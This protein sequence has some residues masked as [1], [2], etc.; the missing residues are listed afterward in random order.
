MSSLN[1]QVNKYISDR[2]TNALIYILSKAPILEFFFHEDLVSEYVAKEGISMALHSLSYGFALTKKIMYV[3]ILA[4]IIPEELQCHV[5]VFFSIIGSLLSPII[6]F[7]MTEYEMIMLMRA[8]STRYVR[9]QLRTFIIKDVA[10]MGI[11]L[12]LLHESFLIE[13]FYLLLYLSIHLIIEGFRI[14]LIER[15]GFEFLKPWINTVILGSAA[16]IAVAMYFLGLTIRKQAL[17]FCVLPLLVCGCLCWYYLWKYPNYRRMHSYN[18]TID[19]INGGARNLQETS[20]PKISE[21]ERGS[22]EKGFYYINKIFLQRYRSD[23]IGTI[24]ISPIIA[25]V[26]GTAFVIVPFFLPELKMNIMHTIFDKL[27]LLFYLMYCAAQSYQRYIRLNFME[28]DR[29]MIS[30]SFYRTK[31][32]ISLNLR[33][34]LRNV[35]LMGAPT[36]FIISVALLAGFAIHGN[37]EFT[38][39]MLTVAALLPLILHVFFAIYTVAMYYL[40]QP[41]SF[42]GTSASKV[43]NAIN[44]ILY[45]VVYFIFMTDELTFSPLVL[46]IIT[47]ILAVISAVLFVLVIKLAPSNFRVRG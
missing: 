15:N 47:A 9:H 33:L 43:Y 13:L 25:L 46:M 16:A 42:D 32:A 36:A 17:L 28:L 40:L 37:G 7:S 18:L 5:F 21:K 11:A 3:E 29:Y 34:R 31:E 6:S 1:H 19:R 39:M 12:L 38:P 14:A 44:Y 23:F 27:Q 26:A 41:Y 22:R 4:N 35:L 2:K 10:M 45:I 8:D 20:A 30:Y 24:M